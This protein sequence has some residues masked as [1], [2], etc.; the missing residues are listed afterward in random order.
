MGLEGAEK[1]FELYE[2]LFHK[3]NILLS[4]FQIQVKAYSLLIVP[5]KILV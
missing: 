5:N 2:L 3:L 4:G 1:P